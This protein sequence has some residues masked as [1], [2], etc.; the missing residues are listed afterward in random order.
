MGE[1]DKL[2]R[3]LANATIEIDGRTE[4][5]VLDELLTLSR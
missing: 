2:Y 3:K 5:E 1:R 4:R